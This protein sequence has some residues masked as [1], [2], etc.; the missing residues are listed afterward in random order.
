MGGHKSS[1][2]NDF[3]AIFI[4]GACKEVLLYAVLEKSLEP[5]EFRSLVRDLANLTFDGLR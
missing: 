1:G 3:A 2:L 4:I 5:K